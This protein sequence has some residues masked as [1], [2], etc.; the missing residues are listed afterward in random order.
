MSERSEALGPWAGFGA[1]LRTW[2]ERRG[3]S[4]RGLAERIRWDH[5]VIGKWEQGRNAPSAAAITALEGVLATGG[6]LTEA[7]LRA[8]AMEVE[9]LRG[10]IRRL[11]NRT[12]P[13]RAEST[14]DVDH[15][16]RR[17]AMQFLAALGTTAVVPPSAIQ[18]IL[19]EVNRAI[20]DRGDFDLDDW[21][22]TVWEYGFRTNSGPLGALIG[23]LT[24]DIV[25]VKRLLDDNPTPSER[26]GL[27]RIIAGL[28][29]ILAGELTHMQEPSAARRAH[30]TARRAADASGDRDLRVAVRAGHAWNAYALGEHP[31]IVLRRLDD[32]I[33]IANGAPSAGLA[34]AYATRAFVLAVQA[35]AGDGDKDA[36]V[37]ALHNLHDVFERLPASATEDEVSIWGFAERA[38]RFS[39]AHTFALT[40]RRREA[41][42]A[43][44]QAFA[45]YPPELVHGLANLRLIQAYTLV[46]QNDI[47][48]GLDHAMA[49]V[50]DVPITPA[51]RRITGQV[52]NALPEKARSLPAA[53]ELHALAISGASPRDV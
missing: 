2:R 19:S 43:I 26:A 18:A 15:M 52:I 21:D 10:E 3:L 6:E 12:L 7:A 51:R 13:A 25:Q 29:Q 22:R 38:L 34:N 37:D 24:A 5:S 16:E 48:Q 31:R 30:A 53:R 50:Q 17:A 42:Q 23:E 9:R 4:L 28:N 11:R 45:L 20:G 1:V 36:A 46:R 8:Q 47:P 27:L 14:E 41:E 32:A 39:E 40:G 33:H 49:T 44:S 35:D